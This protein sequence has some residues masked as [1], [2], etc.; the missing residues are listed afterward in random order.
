LTDVVLATI[1]ARYSHCAFGLR[2]LRANLNQGRESAKILEFGL[3]EWPDRIVEAILAEDP[4]VVGLGVYIW[5]VELMGEVTSLLKGIRP[6]LPLVLGGPEM[7]AVDDLPAWAHQAD[8]VVSGEGELVFAGLCDDLLAGKI[9]EEKFRA[10]R[11]DDLSTLR[12]P[13]AEYTEEDIAQ[14]TLYVESSRG[15][16]YGCEFC[17]S[18]LDRK[19]RRF[20]MAQVLGALEDLWRRGARSFKFVDR[21]LHLAES[22]ELLD[23][24]LKRRDEPGL[25]VHFEL[26]PEALDENML[27]ALSGFSLNSLQLEVGVQS[28]NPDVCARIGRKISADKVEQ[29]LLVLRDKTQAHIHADLV[30][31]LP[32]ETWESVKDSFDRLFAL[33]PDEIQ[34][35]I[36]KRLRGVAIA[37]H[38]EA[39]GM[40]YRDRA[41]YDVL[42]TGELS[43][44]RMQRLKRFARGFERMVNSGNFH[45]SAAR[46]LEGPSAFDAFM[47]FS[48]WLFERTLQ[49]VGMSISRKTGMIFDY[50]TEVLGVDESEAAGGL[51]ADF[52][53]LGRKKGLPE[54]VR[55]WA[56][57]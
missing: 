12:L 19:V 28:F 9:P 20:P 48:D 39:F 2:Y 4:K 46:L 42:Q 49:D 47:A 11:V 6:E 56:G 10:G 35:G 22:E 23:F 26:V 41:P 51:A 37:R 55:R 57:L 16:P 14:R 24:F 13:Y 36:L 7:I 21:S 50:L 31:G 32:G 29:A 1:N 38:D 30:L 45:S 27:D 15:C 33:R 8:F 18:S 40:V 52:D 34:V 54:K 5:N 43:F 17:L 3:E 53:R 25:F 44:A